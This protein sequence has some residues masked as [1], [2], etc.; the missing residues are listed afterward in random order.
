MGYKVELNWVLKLP[1]Q[2]LPRESEQLEE[3]RIYEFE[4]EEERIYPVNIP[5][6]LVDDH[7]N[8]WAEVRILE[9]TIG[10]GRTTG[11]YM[12]LSIPTTKRKSM[13][14]RYY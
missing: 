8:I 1:S 14:S 13:Y 10:Y 6:E 11:K 9:L 3:G 12:V 4:K 2:Q 7:W 5:I